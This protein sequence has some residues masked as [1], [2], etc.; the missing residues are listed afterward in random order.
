MEVVVI[1][2]TVYVIATRVLLVLRVKKV[3][4]EWWHRQ[5]ISK[6]YLYLGGALPINITGNS[7]GVTVRS[8]TFTFSLGLKEITEINRENS[9]V[10]NYSLQDISNF[11]SR[12]FP[13]FSI[14]YYDWL[15]Y[16]T[17]RRW[18]LH[19][20]HKTSER[21]IYPFSILGCKYCWLA[22]AIL[23]T[24]FHSPNYTMWNFAN[25]T[26]PLHPDEI[27]LTIEIFGWPFTSVVNKL[28]L[29]IS[30]ETHE[31]VYSFYLWLHLLQLIALACNM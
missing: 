23:I 31:Q 1:A 9:P 4:L 10:Y 21:G 15:L 19:I 20:I 2:L 12:I 26:F 24:F 13:P 7:T 29:A 8:N 6:T 16:R 28:E 11:T 18:H 25:Q 3:N 5:T 30:V 27:K 14:T 17:S 22:V